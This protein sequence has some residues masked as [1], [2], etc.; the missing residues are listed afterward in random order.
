MYVNTAHQQ[1][2]LIKQ[3]VIVC[4]FCSSLIIKEQNVSNKMSLWML[5]QDKQN[6]A[7]FWKTSIRILFVRLRQYVSQRVQ[8]KALEEA[9]RVKPLKAL[10][11]SFLKLSILIPIVFNCVQLCFC[12]LCLL[13]AVIEVFLDSF[14]KS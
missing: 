7:K 14:S 12:Q 10:T 3:Q 4:C 11:I 5:K 9:Y 13:D 8:D 2:S 6:V 1:C